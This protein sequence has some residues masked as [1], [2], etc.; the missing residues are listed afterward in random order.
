M[1]IVHVW[2]SHFSTNPWLP[3]CKERSQSV[4]WSWTLRSRRL[5]V[6][7][8]EWKALS[9]VNSPKS[10]NSFKQCM[11][12]EDDLSSTTDYDEK[13]PFL[14]WV[15]NENTVGDK[16]DVDGNEGYTFCFFLIHLQT[17]KERWKFVPSCL[18]KCF[19]ILDW[20]DHLKMTMK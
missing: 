15:V 6:M 13:I 5:F 9:E 19:S 10:I 3:T 11:M 2:K 7:K 17:Q 1:K 12:N 16:Q 8:R 4:S 14:T 20:R 18:Y